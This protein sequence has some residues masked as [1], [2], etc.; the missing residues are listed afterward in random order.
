MCLKRFY[1]GLKTFTKPFGA[2]QRRA[3]IKILS[4][5]FLFVR[6]RKGYSMVRELE[7]LWGLLRNPKICRPQEQQFQ[8]LTKIIARPHDSN[9]TCWWWRDN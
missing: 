4:Q 6:D 3:R 9:I 1:E 7:P 8:D 2:P 5:S